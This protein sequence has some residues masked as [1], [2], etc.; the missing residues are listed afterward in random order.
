MLILSDS[1]E[2]L[3]SYPEA[4]TMPTYIEFDFVKGLMRIG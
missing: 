2:G 1:C 3:S 4:D